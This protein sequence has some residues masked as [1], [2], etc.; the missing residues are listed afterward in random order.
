MLSGISPANHIK[1]DFHLDF[2]L[3]YYLKSN[4]YVNI[5]IASF[6]LSCMMAASKM[7][8]GA[9]NERR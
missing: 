4:S 9:D 8:T 5:L 1:N 3:K 7:Q 6:L 2:Y